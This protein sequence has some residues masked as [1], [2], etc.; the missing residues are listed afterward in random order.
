MTA[1]TTNVGSY[2]IGV[3]IGGTHTDMIVASPSGLTRSKA[4]T[5]HDDYSKGILDAIAVAGETL[6]V[7]SDDLIQGCTSFINSSTIVTNAVTEMRGAKVGVLITRGFKDTFRIARGARKN[8]YDDHVQTTPPEVVARDCI[9]EVTERTLPD[10]SQAV[11][12]DEA[13]V[14]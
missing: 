3:D 6:G 5:T 1:T 4:F 12:L 11:A 10:G 7:T 9:E 2:T 14:R 8:D 13:G